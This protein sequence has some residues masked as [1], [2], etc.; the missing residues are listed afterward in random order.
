[1]TNHSHPISPKFAGAV[2]FA[3]YAVFFM[4]FAKYTLLT[5]KDTRLLPF[6]SS[7]FIAAITGGIAGALLGKP[8][9]KNA[10]WNRPFLIG[11]LLALLSLVLGSFGVLAH[12]YLHNV[13]HFSRWQDYFVVYGLVLLS[14]LMTVGIWLVPLT[15]LVSVYFNKRFFPG[16]LLADKERF[17]KAKERHDN[18]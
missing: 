6:F 11:I 14:L 2:F 13:L 16:L 7:L 8:L 1:M 3:L 12:Y 4:L 18:K 10:K 17:A 15:G 5:L 9:A